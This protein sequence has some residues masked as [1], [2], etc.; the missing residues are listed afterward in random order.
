MSSPEQLQD[1]SE[2]IQLNQEFP[3]FKPSRTFFQPDPSY[4]PGNVARSEIILKTDILPNFP[5]SLGV[6]NRPAGT[7]SKGFVLTPFDPEIG[8]NVVLADLDPKTRHKRLLENKGLLEQRID[9]PLASHL[10]VAQTPMSKAMKVLGVDYGHDRFGFS[11]EFIDVLKSLR[12]LLDFP[13]GSYMAGP[14]PTSFANG[15]LDFWF[16]YPVDTGPLPVYKVKPK[17]LEFF[18]AEGFPLLVPFDRPKLEAING[19]F[20]LESSTVLV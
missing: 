19:R 20:L 9:S 1:S 10:L 17:E 3:L 7:Y 15:S 2:I 16:F 5:L 13:K 6:V 4:L 18:V 12:L 14:T 11:S 8:N